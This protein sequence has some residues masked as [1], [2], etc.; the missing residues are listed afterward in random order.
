MLYFWF[1]VVKN[2]LKALSS[3]LTQT[4]NALISPSQKDSVLGMAIARFL[5]LENVLD[6]RHSFCND[7]LD[8]LT[9]H[10]SRPEC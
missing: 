8:F 5:R 9:V 6:I 1:A 7:A 2:V 3:G 4:K 10:A